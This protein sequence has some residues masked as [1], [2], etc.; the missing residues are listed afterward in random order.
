MKTDKETRYKRVLEFHL[1]WIQKRKVSLDNKEYLTIEG[2][3]YTPEQIKRNFIE[4]VA[5]HSLN[6]VKYL[7]VLNQKAEALEYLNQSAKYYEKTLLMNIE[8]KTGSFVHFWTAIDVSIINSDEVLMKRIA[9]LISGADDLSFVDLYELMDAYL[10][11]QCGFILDDNEAVEKHLEE[12]KK[13]EPTWKKFGDYEGQYDVYHGIYVKDKEQLLR[14]LLRMMDI[15]KHRNPQ[16][17]QDP[18]FLEGAAILKMAEMK[19]LHVDVK[20]DIPAK[21]HKY[22]P[23]ALFE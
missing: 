23:M 16:L 6:A 12:L 13:Y 4:S 11:V 5:E 7:L 3:R 2:S 22:L 18:W 21:Y 9:S 8:L 19:G 15:F 1:E 14:G 17:M 10:R 20:E